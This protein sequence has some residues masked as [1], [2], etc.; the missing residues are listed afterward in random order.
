MASLCRNVE[1]CFE[2]RVAEAM[3]ILLGLHFALESCLVPIVLEFD[4]LRV[5]NLLKLK[6]VPDSKIGV[7]I[8]DI[9][10]IVDHSCSFSFNF[11]PR[12]ANKV[13]HGLAKLT[14]AYRGEFV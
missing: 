6:V 9:S 3:A 8:H 13:A 1:G 2:P 11:V 12:L 4:A 5:V 14:L 7:V 10:N